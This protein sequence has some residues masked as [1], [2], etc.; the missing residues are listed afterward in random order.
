M[1]K[2]IRILCLVAAM[3]IGTAVAW[4]QVTMQSKATSMTS[5]TETGQMTVTAVDKSHGVLQ[6]GVADKAAFEKQMEQNL[7]ETLYGDFCQVMGKKYG[8]VKFAPSLVE[9]PE[10]AVVETWYQDQTVVGSVGE[11]F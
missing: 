4:S 1:E 2:T 6:E 3:W 9:L 11:T 10:G 5:D 8:N 7:R